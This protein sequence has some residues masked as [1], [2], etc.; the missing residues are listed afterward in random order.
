MVGVNERG[1]TLA[2]RFV[3]EADA[4]QVRA[5]HLPNGTPMV[6]AGVE[7]PGGLA[8]GRLLAEVCLGGLGIVGFG[9]SDLDGL[10]LPEV[11]VAV[12]APAVACLGSQYGGWRVEVPGFTAIGSGPARALARVETALFEKLGYRDEATQTVLALETD[13]LP[14]Q[15][16]ADLVARACGV[17]PDR[18]ILVA[19]ATGS[20]AGTVQIAARSVE[21]AV[22][23]LS[24]LGFDPRKVRHGVGRCPLAPPTGD[25]L[26][27]MGWTN[28]CIL[29]G[30]EVFL[31]VSASDEEVSAIIERIP[32]GASSD[33]GTPFAD[34][35]RQT[36]DFY[37]IDPLLFSPARV[38][39]GNVATGRIFRAGR[40]APA[41]LRKSLG[42]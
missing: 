6:D 41:V 31:A 16:A 14:P 4:L 34:L 17:D 25:F 38:T 12:D 13:R 15:A 7:A 5:T 3:A 8:A 37:K 10:V 19:A 32:S 21:T 2:R 39:I 20:A 40:L 35:F 30:S 23:K 27:A 42:A 22:H 33:F 11:T 9:L 24:E 36:G 29:Y 26:R 1:F 28:D 18:V